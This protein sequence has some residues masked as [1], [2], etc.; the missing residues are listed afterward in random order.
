[1]TQVPINDATWVR[2]SFLLPKLARPVHTITPASQKY[3]N[4]S[5][6][7]NIAINPP[8]QFT[9]FADPMVAN[10]A[11]TGMGRYYSENIDDSAVHLHIRAGVP[12][13]NSLTSF[14]IGPLGKKGFYDPSMSYLARTGMER[15]GFYSAGKL[16]GFLFTAPIQPIIY[17]G[18]AI[19]YIFNVKPS[20]RWYNIKPTMPLYWSAVNVM[21]NQ[22]AVNM[23]LVPP[24]L[25]E[26]EA[27]YL[28][29]ADPAAVR[30]TMHQLD[31]RIFREDGSIDIFAVATKAQRLH[32]AAKREF[33][34]D[35]ANIDSR[36]KVISNLNKYMGEETSYLYTDGKTS[37]GR[38]SQLSPV[39][40]EATNNLKDY[41]A[42]YLSSSEGKAEEK[43]AE[44]KTK[45][46]KAIDGDYGGE[47]AT[48]PSDPDEKKGFF[49]RAA[50]S[51]WASTNDAAE[52]VTFNVRSADSVSESVSNSAG[53]SEL[54]QKL[55]G[56]N[57]AGRSRNFHFAGGNVG[58]NVL[59]KGLEGIGNAV[60]NFS[61]G[62]LDMVGM[63]GLAAFNGAAFVD[64]PKYYQDSSVTFPRMSYKLELRSPYG[65]PVARM[66]YETI[67]MLMLLALALPRSV[68]KQSYTSPFLVEA[69]CQGRGQVRLGLI[70]S[71][72]ITRGT[73][74]MPWSRHGEYRGIDVDFSIM[75]LS[76]IMSMPLNS[77]MDLFDDENPYTD[78]LATLGGLSLS[79]QTYGFSKL[80]IE[81]TR[82]ITQGKL[83][84]SAE[85]LGMEW[86]SGTIGKLISGFR[87]GVFYE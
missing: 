17:V 31:S 55:N 15:G 40:G 73:G 26:T 6:G 83:N 49:A 68:G 70:D 21:V 58:D 75:D 61:V 51:F 47:G 81:L 38:P 13:F 59:M 16:F 37:N 22:V 11:N 30:N 5:L 39:T 67:P 1:M 29:G 85:K 46:G 41:L 9:E 80:N 62:A 43:K 56:M 27:D 14:F 10:R 8:P 35:L 78:Y 33:E 2:R 86:G 79:E 42:I 82:A 63:S 50:S 24:I 36:E 64:I 87:P 76:S 19:K 54:A 23:N 74:N 72:T 18:R 12:R 84:W 32:D 71:L 4:T 3:T 60:K 45:D 53:E 25:G 65:H 57:S 77:D 44:V 34:E 69:Y 28:E 7:G 48:V 66:Q 20:S 52:F